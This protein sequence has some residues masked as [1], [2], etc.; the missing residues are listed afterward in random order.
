[1]LASL[2]DKKKT[3]E[4]RITAHEK[5]DQEYAQKE[6]EITLKEQDTEQKLTLLM[7]RIEKLAGKIGWVDLVTLTQKVEDTKREL[8]RV[9]KQLGEKRSFLDKLLHRK[10][11]SS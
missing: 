9:L 7:K 2:E 11:G 4:A 5:K 10:E 6:R 1:M 8:D 3:I